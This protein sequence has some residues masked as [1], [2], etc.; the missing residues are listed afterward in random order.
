MHKWF[1]DEFAVVVRC[2][3]CSAL[4]LLGRGFPLNGPNS[5]VSH[6]AVATNLIMFADATY[7]ACNK[8]LKQITSSGELYIQGVGHYLEMPLTDQT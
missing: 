1:S 7:I 5:L 8:L 4:Y 2:Q 6:L 3:V